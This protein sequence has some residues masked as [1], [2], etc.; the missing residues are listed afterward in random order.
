MHTACSQSI[1]V[2]DTMPRNITTGGGG[3]QVNKFETGLQWWPPDVSSRGSVCH[4]WYPGGG[5]RG[6]RGQ[7]QWGPMVTDRTDACENITFP[8][9]R[10][11]AVKESNCVY[12]HINKIGS[13]PLIIKPT[14]AMGRFRRRRFTG[15]SFYLRAAESLIGNQSINLVAGP[16]WNQ[17]SR[18]LTNVTLWPSKDSPQ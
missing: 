4:V 8:Q 2:L 16:A 6:D 3:T 13:L 10:L 14:E 9:F 5:G 17:S 15:W 18:I 1:D 7:L 11:R 12:F